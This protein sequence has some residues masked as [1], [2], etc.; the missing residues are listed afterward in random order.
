MGGGGGQ[1]WP[2]LGLADRWPGVQA[3]GECKH[4]SCLA[5]RSC[6]PGPADLW[7]GRPGA[8]AASAKESR[9]E[10]RQQETV[11]SICWRSEDSIKCEDV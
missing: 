10:P 11:W 5:P 6:L 1:P 7:P 3:A 4:E 9:P 8:A 2:G